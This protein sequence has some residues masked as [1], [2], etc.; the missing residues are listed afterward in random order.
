MTITVGTVVNH[1]AKALGLSVREFLE[2]IQEAVTPPNRPGEFSKTMVKDYTAKPGTRCSW[3][4]ASAVLD[5]LYLQRDRVQDSVS[6]EAAR[7]ASMDILTD[8]KHRPKRYDYFATDVLPGVAGE[9]DSLVGAYAIVRSDT[10]DDRRLRQDLLIL[11]HGGT[12]EKTGRTLAMFLTPHLVARG[13]WGISENTLFV[14]GYLRRED[15]SFSFVTLQFALP[16]DRREAFGGILCGTSS[17]EGL[18]VTLPL[19]ALR[20]PLSNIRQKLQILCD[21]PDAQL[22]TEFVDCG[23]YLQDPEPQDLKDILNKIVLNSEKRIV[24]A[25]DFVGP[26]RTLRSP[27]QSFI[28]P[29]LTN[30]VTADSEGTKGATGTR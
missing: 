29:G 9:I 3:Q 2:R 24:E 7:R 30:F 10:G 1:A 17:I 22:R 5:Y 13:V 15:F 28:L 21:R 27:P 6:F 26:L 11:Q 8:R 23:A 25:K 4:F 20:L 16:T 14:I 12:A 18:P 19:L